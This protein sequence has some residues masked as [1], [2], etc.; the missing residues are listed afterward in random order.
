ME[1]FAAGA[2]G[3]AIPVEALAS[4]AV[5]RSSTV[6]RA[7]NADRANKDARTCGQELSAFRAPANQALIL[8]AK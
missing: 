4:P 6:G 5:S 8:L 2:R 3:A 7:R 1:D